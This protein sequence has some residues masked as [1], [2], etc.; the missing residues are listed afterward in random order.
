MLDK[1]KAN[2]QLIFG[3]I[4]AIVTGAYFYEKSKRKSAEAIADNKEMLDKLNEGDKQLAKNNGQLQSEEAKR[5]EIKKEAEDAKR[6]DSK[7][8]TDFLN[9]RS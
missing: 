6:D 2:F 1:I 8:A 4:L 5:E 3:I 9:K 7:D